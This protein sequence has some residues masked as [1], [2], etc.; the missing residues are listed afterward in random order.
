[1]RPVFSVALLA[2]L[3]LAIGCNGNDSSTPTQSPSSPGSTGNTGTS[4]AQGSNVQPLAAS[5]RALC[6]S[7]I[8]MPFVRVPSLMG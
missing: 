4:S 5:N 6:Q 3:L 8:T 2:T 7:Q 1:M